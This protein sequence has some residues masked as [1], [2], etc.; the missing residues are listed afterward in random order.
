MAH[1]S[2]SFSALRIGTVGLAIVLGLPVAAA[3][4]DSRADEHAREQAARATQVTPPKEDFLERTVRIVKSSGLFGNGPFGFRPV[5]TSVYSGGGM[6]LGAGYE[7]RLGASA[8]DL[9]GAWSINN[10][11]RVSAALQLPPMANGRLSFDAEANWVDAPTVAF[12][13]VGNDSA[14]EA[15]STFGYRPTSVELVSTVHPASI[16]TIGAGVAYLAIDRVAAIEGPLSVVDGS[17]PPGLGQRPTYVRTRAF[18][19]LDWRH[20]PGYSGSGGLYRIELQDHRDRS[21]SQLGFRSVEGEVVQLIPVLRANWVVALRALATITG[22]PEGHAVPFYLMPSL[23]GN[24]NV[25]G[26]SSLRYRDNHRLVL[27]AEYRWPTA[28]FMDMGLFYDVGKVAHE[29]SELNLRDL[30]RSYGIGARFHGLKRTVLQLELARNDQGD[31]RLVT[32]INST[33]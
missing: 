6:A 31:L 1:H 29:R 8:I 20:A 19:E 27:N 32:A 10:F 26:Y 33:F 5:V 28:R 15:R 7:K 16:A 23:G 13:G 25:R 12:Y 3:A 9:T 24:H 14:T 4:Q 30:K 2:F 17:A 11:R 18:A 22:T 21:G